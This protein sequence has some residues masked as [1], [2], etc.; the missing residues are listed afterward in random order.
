MNKIKLNVVKEEKIDNRVNNTGR[1][2][3]KKVL[4]KLD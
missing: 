4:G 3:N 1:P 2:V